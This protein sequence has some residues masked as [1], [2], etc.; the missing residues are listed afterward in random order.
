MRLQSAPT[1]VPSAPAWTSLYRAQPG[2]RFR[3]TSTNLI[4]IGM[5][6]PDR[7]L[8]ADLWGRPAKILLLD[9][10]LKL[11]DKVSGPGGVE[12]TMRP[13]RLN[14]LPGW[15][16]KMAPSADESTPVLMDC[17]LH[18]TRYR[19]GNGPGQE[20]V[21]LVLEHAGRAHRAWLTGCPTELLLCVEATL[22]QEDCA[23]RKLADLQ[24]IRLVGAGGE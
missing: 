3:I 7:V 24:D 18:A 8:D 15:P 13:I 20:S 5:E 11:G 21:E 19:P 6:H 23:G 16:P 22:N 14:E 12:F 17:V 10:P 9:Q 2:G 4:A 1:A